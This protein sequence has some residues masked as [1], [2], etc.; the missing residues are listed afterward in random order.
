[1]V[2]VPQYKNSVLQA[3]EMLSKA[4]RALARKIHREMKLPINHDE[5]T[6]LETIIHAQGIIQF[7]IAK[8]IFMKRSYVCKFLSTL[9]EKGY[10]YRENAVRGKRQIISRNYTTD[11]G[12]K[13]YNEIKEIYDK[14]AGELFCDYEVDELQKAAEILFKQCK[15]VISVH[16]LK[17]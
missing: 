13:I 2:T 16:K 17:I 9:E 14:E 5:F 10:I 3:A 1:M 11:L 15:K 4:F 6:I 7:D 12:V 8:E